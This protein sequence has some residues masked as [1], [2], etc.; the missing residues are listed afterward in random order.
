MKS[1]YIYRNDV[2]EIQITFNLNDEE[3]GVKTFDWE[4]VKEENLIEVKEN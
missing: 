4:E 1:T 3:T 2:K